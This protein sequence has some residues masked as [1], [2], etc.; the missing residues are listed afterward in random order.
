M[1][2]EATGTLASVLPTTKYYEIDSA[3]VGTRFAVWVTLPPRYHVEDVAYPVVYQPDGN[4][5]AP[6]TAAAHGL[7]RD[8]PINPI[9]PFIQVSVGYTGRDAGR[10]L[11]VRARDL[12]PPGEPLPPG[13]DE[14]TI[15]VLPAAGL[16][17]E[18]DAR[19]YL[20]NLRN[21][22]A[23]LFLAF[24]IDELDPALRSLFRISDHGTGLHGYSYGGLFAAYAAVS[25]DHFRF[26]GAGSPGIVRNGSRI[27]DLFERAAADPSRATA[28]R[29]H[30]TVGERELTSP[31]TYQEL[32][33]AGSVELILRAGA[34][35]T[36][37]LKVTSEFIP[38]ESH[39]T[40][41][42][43]SWFAFLRACYPAAGTTGFL[44]RPPVSTSGL[45]GA[46]IA[47]GAGTAA[48][49]GSR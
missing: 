8:D 6:A 39:A 18:A 25:T 42:A 44:D 23:D 33:A 14:S 37:A 13:A 28:R 10:R 22:R 38:H 34:A 36:N 45:T 9:S 43:A 27:L 7:L 1:L 5:A 15:G 40:G 46:P 20:E 19:L 26:V 3:G 21:P 48:P 32:V 16:L 41:D 2:V 24:L 35:P 29:L 11:A 47:A 49:P 12:L 30:V 31:S 4:K 17:S